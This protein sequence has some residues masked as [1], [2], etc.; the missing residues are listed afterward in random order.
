MEEV[1]KTMAT[2]VESLTPKAREYVEAERKSILH[3]KSLTSN[4]TAAEIAHLKDQNAQFA[5][6]L[7][8]EKAKGERA[9]NDLI[10]RVSGLLGEF[11]AA[12]DKGLRD[13]VGLVQDRNTT[14]E[15]GLREVEGV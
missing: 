14:A 10:Q 7:D 8:A 2:L 12:R 15:I 3:A 13:A 6:L 11:T 4:A 9:K 5:R 1:L